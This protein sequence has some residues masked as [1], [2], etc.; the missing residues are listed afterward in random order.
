M[1]VLKTERLFI[2]QLKEIDFQDSIEHRMDP[3]VCKYISKPMTIK[4]VF[5]F[6]IKHSKAWKGNINE[7]LALGV[8][9]RNEDKLI[10]ELMVKYKNKT[11]NIVEIGF[12]FNKKYHSMGYAFEATQ[13][14]IYHLFINLKVNKIIGICDTRNI[15]SYSLMQKLGMVKTTKIMKETMIDGIP[16]YQMEYFIS[17][18]IWM[19]KFNKINETIN[20]EKK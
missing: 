11:N 14:L 1:I 3:E 19:D 4:E 15:A 9:L 10:G 8:I 6:V 7:R 2:R 20:Q 12:R 16:T 18:R 13:A 17:K 5:Q